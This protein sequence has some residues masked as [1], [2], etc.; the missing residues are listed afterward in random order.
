MTKLLH[1]TLQGLFRIGL[2]DFYAL[3]AVGVCTIVKVP[4]QVLTI[5]WSLLAII[6]MVSALVTLSGIC[7]AKLYRE[8]EA[9]SIFVLQAGLAALMLAAIL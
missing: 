4:D 8:F 1:P 5:L 9:I 2:F 7:L 6:F 3:L